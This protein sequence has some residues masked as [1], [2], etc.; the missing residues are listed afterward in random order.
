[1]C[2][3]VH[4]KKCSY[5][6]KEYTVYKWWVCKD[7]VYRFCDWNAWVAI[8]ENMSLSKQSPP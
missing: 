6:D 2:L 3:V 5:C 7:S 8:Q 4:V 1:M